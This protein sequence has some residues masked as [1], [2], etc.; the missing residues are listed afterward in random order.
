MA[1]PLYDALFGRHAGSGATF[2]RLADGAEWSYADFV[3]QAARFA[4]T[5]SLFTF[6]RS[7]M[8]LCT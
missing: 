6:F 2:L 7:V 5:K 1:N 3:G 4:H 8:L